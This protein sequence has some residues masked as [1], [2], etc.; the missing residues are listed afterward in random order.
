M[1]MRCIRM[2]VLGSAAL[3]LAGCFLLDA[4]PGHTGFLF[5]NADGGLMVGEGRN[6]KMGEASSEGIIGIVRGDASI[7][8]AMEAGNISKIHHVDYHFQNILGIVSTYTTKVYG[9]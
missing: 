2:A 4:T 1:L 6:L 5:T 9:E 7:S 3:Y 8:A